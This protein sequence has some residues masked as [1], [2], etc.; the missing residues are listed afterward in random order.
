MAHLKTLGDTK[1]EQKIIIFHSQWE[2][3]LG[4][5]K[6]SSQTKYYF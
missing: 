5:K 3:E 6:P 1:E 4:L 2:T